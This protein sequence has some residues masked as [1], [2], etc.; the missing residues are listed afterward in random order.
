MALQWWE[1]TVEYYFIR[2]II[3]DDTLAMP[4][5]GKLESKAG[6]T[7][8]SEE[9]TFFL[10]EFK[11]DKTSLASEKNKFKDNNM[12]NAKNALYLK[13]T[14][15][16]LVYGTDEQKAFDL[17]AKTYFSDQF[18]PPESLLEKGISE[19]EFKS[20]I[21]ELSSYKKIE[22]DS[23]DASSGSFGLVACVG[24]NKKVFA[25]MNIEEARI[26]LRLAPQPTPTPTKKQT[27]TRKFGI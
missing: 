5:D 26:T 2:N 16:F 27:I 25:C 4:L 12:D 8:F 23:E 22:N 11:K 1:K 7:I 20:Y 19:N 24:K 21:D 3:K 14:H 6:D 15:H 17:K 9:D 10:V 13:D 18:F